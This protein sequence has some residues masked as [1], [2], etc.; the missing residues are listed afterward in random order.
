MRPRISPARRRWTASGLIKIRVRSTATGAQ[1]NEALLLG[2]AAPARLEL[3]RHRGGLDRGLAVG[4]HLP[5]RLE[6]RLARRASLLQARRADR[7][8]EEAR[9]DLG[10]ADGAAL[11]ADREPVLHGADLELS[12]ADVLEVLGR[13][14]QHVEERTDEG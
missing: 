3:H 8:D 2:S 4:A 11:V 14:E 13:P 6:R 5:E 10:P 1:C 12:L 7:A 9:V